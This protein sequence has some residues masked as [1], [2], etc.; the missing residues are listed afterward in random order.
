MMYCSDKNKSQKKISK[1]VLKAAAVQKDVAECQTTAAVN[2]RKKSIEFQDL[3]ILET[4]QAL[5]EL[6]SNA[7]VL[8]GNCEMPIQGSWRWRATRKVALRDA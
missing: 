5:F 7:P 6:E 3:P 8:E 2:M 1:K 4:F